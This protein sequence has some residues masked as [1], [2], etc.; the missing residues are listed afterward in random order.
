MLVPDRTRF[1]RLLAG[2]VLLALVSACSAPKVDEGQQGIPN[3]AICNEDVAPKDMPGPHNQKLKKTGCPEPPHKFTPVDPSLWVQDEGASNVQILPVA[4]TPNNG[5]PAGG[6]WLDPSKLPTSTD[7]WWLEDKVP[8]QLHRRKDGGGRAEPFTHFACMGIDATLGQ[9]QCDFEV[10]SK[11]SAEQVSGKGWA[12]QIG[13]D[14]KTSQWLPIRSEVGASG[15]YSA[16]HKDT[17]NGSSTF[18]QTL[19][20]RPEGPTT[21][22]WFLANEWATYEDVME[23]EATLCHYSDAALLV[24]ECLT[25]PGKKWRGE[26]VVRFYRYVGLRAYEKAPPVP[27]RLENK[28]DFPISGANKNGARDWHTLV[29]GTV[30][31]FSHTDTSKWEGEVHA[32]G[33]YA[34]VEGSVT[35][36]GDTSNELTKGAEVA[37]KSTLKAKSSDKNTEGFTIW[38]GFSMIE[39]KGEIVDLGPIF[40]F[41]DVSPVANKGGTDH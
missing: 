17:V 26:S 25:D 28:D 5:L 11:A 32:K 31:G 30:I 15:G 9:V 22:Y 14:V 6:K 4:A 37:I 13:V 41:P 33:K 20:A 8:K 34:M 18:E 3:K 35:V 39:D 12:L 29:W 1:G 10:S 2:G 40:Y 21:V 27:D 38:K 23:V 16:E 36:K 24:K 7:E 19:P